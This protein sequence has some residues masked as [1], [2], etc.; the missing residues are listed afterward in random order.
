MVNTRPSNAAAHPGQVQL[1]PKRKR[2]TAAEM[3]AARDAE[4]SAKV[5]EANK[6]THQEQLLLRIA[7]L[8]NEVQNGAGAGPVHPPVAANLVVKGQA[9]GAKVPQHNVV[10]LTP[11]MDGRSAGKLGVDEGGK[12]AKKTRNAGKYSRA[13]VAAIR[14]ALSSP[15][16][17]GAREKGIMAAETVRRSQSTLT[18]TVD[19]DSDS[20]SDHEIQELDDFSD[21]EYEEELMMVKTEEEPI[22]ISDSE[23]DAMD[24]VLPQVG[25]MSADTQRQYGHRMTTE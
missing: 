19:D 10:A 21:D 20:D 5:I 3:K 23:D 13:D 15:T 14:A 2:R 8:E 25:G 22:V 11:M 1:A 9:K 12:K 24:D 7:Q 6:L 4:E 18:A 16:P 17:L